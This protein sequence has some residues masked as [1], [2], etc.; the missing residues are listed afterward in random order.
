MEIGKSKKGKCT[1][2][3]G[4]RGDRNS[5]RYANIYIYT[6]TVLKLER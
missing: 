1:G 6:Y 4:E 5:Y 2:K 3:N